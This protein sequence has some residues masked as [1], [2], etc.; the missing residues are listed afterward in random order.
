MFIVMGLSLDHGMSATRN[1]AIQCRGRYAHAPSHIF[2]ADIQIT[3][4]G[5]RGLN[6]FL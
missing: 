5:F 2:D 3:Q 4:R 1:M 6:I